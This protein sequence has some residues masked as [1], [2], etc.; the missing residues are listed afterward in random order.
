MAEKGKK[1]KDVTQMTLE[2]HNDV[3]ADIVNAYL[4]D[5]KREVAEGEL[6]EA[7][8]RSSYK[9]R[10]RRIQERDLAKYWRKTELRIFFGFENQTHP[11]PDMPIRVIGY[12]GA[13]Y[14]DQLYYVKGE[15]GKRRNE[16]R[17]NKPLRLKE[18]LQDVPKELEPY[19]NDYRIHVF[20]V[21][22]MSE[23]QLKLL[24][25]DF[26][27][28]ADYFVQM[29]K[30]GDY[31]PPTQTMIHV[32]EVLELMSALTGDDRFEKACEDCEEEEEPKSMCEVLDRVE[33]RGIEQGIEQ[34]IATKFVKDVETLMKNLNLSLLEACKALNATEEDY[35]LAKS[36]L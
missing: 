25:S 11:D 32:K 5:G 34:G 4:F 14:R 3:F 33:R 15:N 7:A 18:V 20:E 6:D 16:R 23:E 19:V 31:V 13:A 21:A 26:R 10:G 1:E 30:N 22:W 9:G 29:R 17:W 12:D 28:V 27:F 36:M 8:T 24:R 35:R 2:M